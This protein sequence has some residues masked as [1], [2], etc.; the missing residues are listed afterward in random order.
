MIRIIKTN[1]WWIIWVAFTLALAAYYAN[2][3]TGDDKD[4]FLPGNASDGHYQI[5][6]KCDTC[7][8]DGFDD[9]ETLQKSCVRC[10]S[11]E[12]KA[13][14]DSHPKKKFTN[15]RNADRV[16]LL[17]ARYCTTCHIEHKTDKTL[18]M[19]VTLPEDYCFICHKDVAKNR[20][21]HKG[22]SFE[23]CDDAGCHNY[24]DNK[25]LYE[26]Y[27]VK[28]NDQKNHL[29]NI[30][31]PKK[32]LKKVFQEKNEKFKIT[33]TEKDIDS[34]EEIEIS[35]K[36]VYQWQ[37][38]AHAKSGVN[39]KDCH[40]KKSEWVFKPSVKLCSKCH[41]KESEG[42]LAS[43]HGMRL[44]EGLPA[45]KVKQARIPMR[46]DAG[47]KS[48]DCQSCHSDHS[49][50]TKNAAIKACLN[51]HDDKHSKSYKKSQHY[52]SYLLSQNSSNSKDQGVTCA[53]CHMPRIS[54]YENYVERTLVD[55][56][57]NN[58]L[59]PNEKMVRAVCMNCHGLKFSLESLADNTLI[60]NNFNGTPKRENK[61]FEM[62]MIREELKRKGLIKDDKK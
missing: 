36:I 47:H 9:K 16:A 11:K 49:F 24:H 14:N 12:L 61:G 34:P 6:K 20:P 8:G 31:L 17:D 22:M 15:P 30:A 2:S 39:C 54:I 18:S 46:S 35:Q 32:D 48:I 50:N 25:A 4:V 55:H 59:R 56:N 7:H 57:Q 26:E 42:F 10:H 29:D 27:L 28:H 40:N 38:T 43:K 58:T 41:D 23:T 13:I 21:S 44:A 60:E 45:M 51:C 62:A 53:T 3:L 1:K 5:E 52:R 19:G 37:T 33:L